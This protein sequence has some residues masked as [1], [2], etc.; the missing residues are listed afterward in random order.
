M[1]KIEKDKKTLRW[2]SQSGYLWDLSA[3]LTSF[4]TDKLNQAYVYR[5]M[6]PVPLRWLCVRSSQGKGDWHQY[7]GSEA[8]AGAEAILL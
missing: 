8:L 2:C 1:Y 5:Q 4:M 6:C 7:G 3:C